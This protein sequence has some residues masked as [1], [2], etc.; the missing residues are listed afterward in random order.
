MKEN[1]QQARRRKVRIRKRIEKEN[2]RVIKMWKYVYILIYFGTLGGA[3]TCKKW[4]FCEDVYFSYSPWQSRLHGITMKRNRGMTARKRKKKRRNQ[5]NQV[6]LKQKSVLWRRDPVIHWENPK[7]T[8]TIITRRT[9]IWVTECC[10]LGIQLYMH[11]CHSFVWFL[12][13]VFVHL[14]P[15]CT[16]LSYKWL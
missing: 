14:K 1:D 3:S 9:W 10:L 13:A 15:R 11:Q 4:F 6:P 12:N 7:W 16:Q 2:Q 8:G 5:Q